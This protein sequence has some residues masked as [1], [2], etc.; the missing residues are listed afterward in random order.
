MT[1]L[2]EFVHSVL[3]YPHEAKAA[4]VLVQANSSTLQTPD[5]T[6]TEHELLWTACFTRIVHSCR[7]LVC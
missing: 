2:A 1:S 3:L 7:S 6:A 5:A 4:A